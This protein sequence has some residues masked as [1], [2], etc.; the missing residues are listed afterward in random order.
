MI[1]IVI[2][3]YNSENT[4][5]RCLDSVLNQTYKNFEAIVVD[6]G[7][8]DNTAELLSRYALADNR[9]IYIKRENGGVGAAR[10]TGLKMVSG[11]YVQFI[12][13]DD[14]ILPD[15][16]EKLRRTSLESDADV[17]VCRFTHSC[18]K[19]FLPAGEYNLKNKED[20][21]K[22]YGDFFTFNVPW[23]KLY[24]RK[25][26]TENFN[27]SLKI[28]EDGLFV[29]TH[30]KNIQKVVV[31]ED[32]LYKYTNAGCAQNA[33]L[34]N[35]FLKR[36]FWETQ[37][38]YWYVFNNTKHLFDEAL[39]AQNLFSPEFEYARSFDMAFWELVKS[40]DSGCSEEICTLEMDGIF[41]Q[42]NF[43]S[44]LKVRGYE[45]PHTPV[46]LTKSFVKKCFSEFKLHS[47]TNLCGSLY[48]RYVDNF[49]ETFFSG[50]FQENQNTSIG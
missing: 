28:F 36:K 24:K 1:S 17:V 6:D 10:N 5:G 35:S 14:E 40:I 30:F 29:L 44:S 25:V 45:L 19:Q 49:F 16:L 22:F 18:F 26:I 20:C 33:S 12:D 13:A 42:K 41:R 37:E 7:S 47:N 15:M 23:N 34:V 31:L 48:L 43:L 3:T 2:P 32:E 9:I 11:D 8:T 39:K 4:L 27:E 38:G 46:H 21:A 50:S